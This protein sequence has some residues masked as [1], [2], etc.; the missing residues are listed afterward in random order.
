ML[1]M[2]KEGVA[3]RVQRLL[4]AGGS[5]VTTVFSGVV[6]ETDRAFEGYPG[7]LR[8]LLGIWIEEIDAMYP[9]QGNRLVMADGSGEYTCSRWCERI[10]LEGAEA[11]A[12]YGDSFYAG[13]PAVTR[14]GNAY[15]IATDPSDEFLDVF[16]GAILRDHAI[17]PAMA[18][19]PGLEVAVRER[20]GRQVFFVLNHATEAATLELPWAARDLLRDE[21]LSGSVQIAARDVYVLERM[22]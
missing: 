13:E 15:Y 1:H 9:E 17:S 14:K 6:D 5:F 21:Q 8:G 10:R 3:D 7:P 4:D 19:P 18:A 20:E 22:S 16:L 11:I 2:V 12:T